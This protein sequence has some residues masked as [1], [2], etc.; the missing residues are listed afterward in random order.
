MTISMKNILISASI[1]A[2]LSAC[3]N[4]YDPHN[5]LYGQSAHSGH[6]GGGYTYYD[7]SAHTAHNS[8]HN[9]QQDQAYYASQPANGYYTQDGY[10]PQTQYYAHNDGAYSQFPNAKGYNYSEA[11]A[12]YGGGYKG[13]KMSR[14]AF[15][16]FEAPISTE[17]GGVTFELRGRIDSVGS[18]S[19]ENDTG[20]NHRFVG[21][22]RFTAEKQLP[23]RF[24]IGATWTGRAEDIGNSGSNEYKGRVRGHIGGSWGTLI[25][26]N[27]QDLVYEDTR[28]LRGAG[29][30]VGRTPRE[31]NLHGDGALGRLS[32]WGGGYQGRFGPT[33]IT[34]VIDE[35]TNYDVGIKFQ[36]PIGNKDYRLSARHNTG[37][38]TAADGLT[39]ID[40]K[41]VT[42]VAEYVFGSTRFDVSGG[43]EQMEAGAIEADRWFTAAGVTKKI[44]V[45]T[46]SAEGLYGEIEGQPETSAIIAAKYDIARGLSATAAVDYQDRQVNV[47]M[48]DIL[49]AK[50]TRALVG[51]S[52]GF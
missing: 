32:D 50:D 24:T 28:R 14:E 4:G 16:A 27:V 18:Y 26:G 22:H 2:F 8:G 35:D 6:H 52:Y 40:T 11:P 17:L 46:L 47:G 43:Y 21:S 29:R 13:S 15:N 38:F 30:L 31:E 12:L 48:L 7:H 5:P 3:S 20:P 42:G 19:I 1:G 36:R 39:E 37:S 41:A 33:V 51:L 49:D 44:G 45:L 9:F 23:N 10:T 34:S 25:G